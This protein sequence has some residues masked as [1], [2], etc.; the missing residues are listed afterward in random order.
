MTE[1][2][3]VVRGCWVWAKGFG[4]AVVTAVRDDGWLWIRYVAVSEWDSKIW[5]ASAVLA[6]EATFLRGPDDESRVILAKRGAYGTDL[7]DP[8][9]AEIEALREQLEDARTRQRSVEAQAEQVRAAIHA[10]LTKAKAEV[11]RLTAMVKFN[12]AGLREDDESIGIPACHSWRV[13]EEQAALQAAH[14]QLAAV[15]QV[16]LAVSCAIRKEP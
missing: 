11:G 8:R 2:S 15:R 1:E 10:E 5:P 12:A 4:D 7:V 13:A 16:W 14:A 9:D 3:K 6:S